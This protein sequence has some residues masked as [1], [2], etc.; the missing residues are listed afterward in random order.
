M[1]V[2]AAW[3]EKGQLLTCGIIR[4][5]VLR[6][7]RDRRILSRMTEL[8]DLVVDA[9]LTPDLWSETARLAWKLDRAGK[10]LPL[11]DLV[12]GTCALRYEA[13]VLSAD[14][15]F[16]SIPRLRVSGSLPAGS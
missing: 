15:H 5:E 1:E 6:G 8:F 14:P 16:R 7:L 9:P 13:V 4:C 11:T 12:I 10:V 3:V 2:L